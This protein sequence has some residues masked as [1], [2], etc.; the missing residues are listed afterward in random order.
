MKKFNVIL[1]TDLKG[2]IGIN[3]N[4]PWKFLIDL[5]F[6]KSI[7]CS[8]SI[9]PS[10]NTLDNILIMGRKTWESM[11]CKSLPNRLSWVITSQYKELNEINTNSKIKFFGNFYSAYIAS[12]IY[13]D[14]DIWV[15]GGYKIYDEALRHWACDKVFWTQVEGIFDTDISINMSDYSIEWIHQI[16]KTD[17]NKKDNKLYQLTFLQG[18]SK[19]LIEQLYLKTMFDI[20]R[21]GEERKT[22]NGITIS[23]FNK[24]LSWDLADGFPLLTTKKMFWKG[25]VEELLFFIRGETDSSKLSD[26]GVKIWESNT[27]REFLDSMGFFHYKVGEMGPM[28][29]YQW[30]FF[31]KSY[32]TNEN[33]GS[34]QLIKIIE[35]IK[36]DPHSRRI[37]MTDYNP[38]QVHQGVLY[39]CHSI[40][41]QF[42][43][44]QEKLYCS[45]YQRSGDFFLGIPFNIASTSLLVHIIS[46]LTGLKPG[47]VNLIMGDYHIYQEHIDQ[48]FEQIKRIP[49]KLPTLQ[50]PNFET[51]EQVEKSKFE[52]YKIINYNSYPVIKAKMI[53]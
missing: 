43:V 53:A 12:T 3:N 7:T 16:I 15:M 28:Y 13:T 44:Q 14:A 6:F 47:I 21:I 22:R 18:F 39:P 42:Y 33:Q 4:L 10:I 19:P 31:N 17:I 9:L 50:I 49:K 48:V 5:N 2:G 24:T 35:E 41:I 37:L 52:D 32:G 36:K 26:V 34:D 1:A 51:L 45:M 27:T 23:L 8:H 11:N 38:Q 20:V 25:I 46:Q 30:R 40:I 29:G